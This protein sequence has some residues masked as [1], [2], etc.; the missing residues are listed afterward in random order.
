MQKAKVE[1]NAA[2]GPL[3]PPRSALSRAERKVIIRLLQDRLTEAPELWPRYETAKEI[4]RAFRR[5]AFYEISSRCNL[6]CE[7]CYYFS[8]SQSIVDEQVRAGDWEE[9][10]RREGERGVTM[11]YFVG[12]EPALEQDRLIAAAQHFPHGNVGTNGIVKLDRSIPFRIGVS[13]WGVDEAIDARLRGASTFGKA[14]RNY[15]GDPRAIFLYTLTRDNLADVERL[16]EICEDHDLPLTFNMYSPTMTYNLAQGIAND[17]DYFRVSNAADNLRWDAETLLEARSAVTRAMERFPRT[18]VYSSS[19]NEWATREGP[20]YDIDEATGIA[21]D[22]HSRMVGTMK[23][24]KGDLRPAIEKC[25]TSAANAG[26]TAAVGRP[27]SNHDSTMC[28]TG[29]L[30]SIGSE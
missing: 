21:K 2:A 30:S 16:A 5:P 23:Y 26:C 3:V 9:F 29:R 25:G 4:V 20:L 14:L 28:K 1:M 12:A 19:Y 24:Y 13:V 17:G 7:G 8:D 10:F 27:N 15:A 18:V 6:K 11:A 22:C